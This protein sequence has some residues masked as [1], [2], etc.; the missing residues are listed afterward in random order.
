MCLKKMGNYE[1][2]QKLQIKGIFFEL[3]LD[4]SQLCICFVRKYQRLDMAYLWFYL[5]K[6][7]QHTFVEEGHRFL[8]FM[9][10]K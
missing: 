1:K 6:I 8:L 2:L 9:I 3:I 7:G 4:L 10:R 5:Q